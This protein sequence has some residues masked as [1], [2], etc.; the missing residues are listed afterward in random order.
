MITLKTTLYDYCVE[1]NRLDLLQ[2][3]HPTKNEPL[4]P[5]QITYG[6]KQKVWWL[7]QKGHPWQAAVYA[8]TGTESGCPYCAGKKLWPGENDLATRRPD[9]A[10][11]WHPTKNEGV[12]P[13]DVLVGS[14]YKAWWVCG[15]GHEWQAIVKSRVNGT[16]CPVCA[17]R[18]LLTGEND[19]ATVYP[20][21]ARQ[22]HPTKNG[23]L[24]PRDVIA[25]SHRKVWWRCDQ[26][27]EWQA[28]ILSRASSGNG[29]P[30]C[31][32]KVILPGDNDLATHFPEIAAQWHPHEERDPDR[33]GALP[34]QQPQ[35]L[36]AMPAGTHLSGQR[37]RQNHER[38]RLSVLHR[39]ESAPRFQ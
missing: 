8:R 25:G 39:P 34:V 29:C 18:V 17:N 4:T 1:Q 24:T 31:A 27:H 33:A 37:G 38:F 21:L 35:G 22:W 28:T 16:G 5:K 6:S 30:V 2:Q 12:T 7:C 14:H 15:K 26:G 11:Q 32:G 19:L 10:A 9:L 36:V 3:W 13:S 20:D 23:T